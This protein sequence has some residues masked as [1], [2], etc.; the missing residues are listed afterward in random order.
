MYW[1]DC[2]DIKS[3]KWINENTA[4]FTTVAWHW[5]DASFSHPIIV[6]DFFR[7]FLVNTRIIEVQNEWMR[8][9]RQWL[10][11]F[12]LCTW[13][14]HGCKFSTVGKVMSSLTYSFYSSAIL[15]IL[16]NDF[17][18]KHWCSYWCHSVEHCPTHRQTARNRHGR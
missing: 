7:D 12:V 16:S 15:M 17:W 6:M 4:D 14:K 5:A 9:W 8:L 18:W 10:N 3:N 11:N 2:S 1:T 13:F